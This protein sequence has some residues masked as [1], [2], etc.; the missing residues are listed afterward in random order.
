MQIAPAH[1]ENN[2]IIQL[3]MQWVVAHKNAYFR[4]DQLLRI[5]PSSPPPLISHPIQF[6]SCRHFFSVQSG[7]SLTTFN[8]S[9]LVVEDGLAMWDLK[10]SDFS[11]KSLPHAIVDNKC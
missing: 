10:K 9:A 6:A 2:V 8:V 11:W 4:S 3:L 5:C 7:L 1:E